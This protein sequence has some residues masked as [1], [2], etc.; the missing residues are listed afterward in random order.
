MHY[1]TQLGSFPE[2]ASDIHDN[3]I[4]SQEELNTQGWTSFLGLYQER[5]Q[6]FAFGLSRAVYLTV[7]KSHFNSYIP[8]TIN[9]KSGLFET[10]SADES[11]KKAHL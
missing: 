7:L 9:L 2:A 4:E 5:Y 8:G 3:I 10:P 1:W 6:D 11:I